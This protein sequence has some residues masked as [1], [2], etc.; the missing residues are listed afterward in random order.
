MVMVLEWVAATALVRKGIATTGTMVLVLQRVGMVLM[1]AVAQTGQ[2]LLSKLGMDLDQ[3]RIQKSGLR[4]VGRRNPGLW[5]VKMPKIFKLVIF[6]S[7]MPP[8]SHFPYL[9]SPPPFLNE[10]LDLI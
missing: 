9:T 7:V 6:L 1:G 5:D 4:M 8:V 3:G 10:H 2:C